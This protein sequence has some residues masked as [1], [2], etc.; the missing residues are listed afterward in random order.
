MQDKQKTILRCFAERVREFYPKARIWAFG[1]RAWGTPAAESDLDLCVV[2]PSFKPEDRI[3]VSDIA[4]EIG[5]EQD[6]HLSTIVI[7][8][9]DFERGPVSASPLLHAIRNEGVAA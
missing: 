4:W 2:L 5:F 3:S 6:M 1:S 9:E 8:E 7:S